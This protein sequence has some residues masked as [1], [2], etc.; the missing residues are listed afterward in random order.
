MNRILLLFAF[1][2]V[3]LGYSQLVPLTLELP[4]ADAQTSSG[5][6]GSNYGTDGT[7]Q[8][9]KTASSVFRS[10]LK[11]N[12]SSIPADAVITS[13][14]L[15]LTPSGVEGIPTT[16]ATELYLDVCNS[17]WTE[18][19]I[20]HSSNISN[21]TL[22]PTVTVSNL[23]SG[24]REFE[25]KNFV[26]A[27]AD[28]R[29]PNEGWR[30]RRKDETTNATTAYYTKEVKTSSYHPKLVIQYYLRSSVSAATIVH[31]STLTSNDGSISPT[32]L[33]GSS[34]TMT[35]RWF[36]SSG[37]QI[38]TSQNLTGVGKGWYGL[39][40][41][42]SVAGDTTYMAFIVGTECEDVSITFDPGP[43]YID[44][45]RFTDFVSGS[46]TSAINYPQANNGSNILMM[47]ERWTNGGVWYNARDVIKFRLWVD[48]GCQVNSAVMTLVGNAH[49]ALGTPNT[50]ELCR[51]TANW[52]EFGVAHTNMP[53]STATGKIAVP[54][55]ATGNGNATP[56]IASFFN[57]WKNN[58]VQNY[59]MLFQLQSYASN[60]YTR[61][62]FHSSDATVAS[63]RPKINFSI[64]TETCNL[65]RKGVT[66]V[67]YP[68][69]TDYADLN[70]TVYPPTWAVPPY[71][72]MISEQPVPDFSAIYRSAQVG[73]P[74]SPFKDT[75]YIDSTIFYN[76]GISATSKS[77]TDV[78]PG[79]YFVS[80][81]DKLGKR[82][83]NRQVSVN[84]A[85]NAANFEVNSGMS[86]SSLTDEF[87]T[88]AVVG[89]ALMY[90]FI[91]EKSQGASISYKVSNNS[92][93]VLIGLLNLSSNLS[94]KTDLVHGFIV[95]GT[96]ASIVSSGYINPS[97]AISPTDEFV[98]TKEGS[99][100]KFYVNGVFKLS[101]A[102]PS[103]F[104]YKTGVLGNGST[105]GAAGIRISFKP[106]NIFSFKKAW[107]NVTRVDPGSCMGSFGKITGTLNVF[108]F[109]SASVINPSMVLTNTST[110][111][112]QP[113]DV[114]V[115]GLDFS[116][117]NLLPGTYTLTIT[118]NW[119]TSPS[120]PVV[121]TMNI[122]VPT[123]IAWQNL[124]NATD[125]PSGSGSLLSTS[126]L[127]GS[128]V[129]VNELLPAIPGNSTIIDFEL[130]LAGYFY[131]V[132]F[133]GFSML[134]PVGNGVA[135]LGLTEG[136][137]S[138]GT[139]YFTGWKFYKTAFSPYYAI[140]YQG[141][142][143]LS[144][145][146]SFLGTDRLRFIY[147]PVS[148]IAKLH[149]LTATGIMGV[150]M[151]QIVNYGLNP[152]VNVKRLH[153]YLATNIANRG[154]VRFST[155]ML[156]LKDIIYAKLERKLLGVK[157]KVTLNKF[158]FFY[159]EE[160]ASTSNLTYNVYDKNNVVV[161]STTTPYL[162]NT[163]PSTDP[164]TGNIIT[165]EYG[166]NRYSLDVTSIS[167]GS[168][169][170]EVINEKNEKLYLRFIK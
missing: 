144:S 134:I 77:F 39:K 99:T 111:A 123:Q 101:T 11:F 81:F 9:S 21:N 93:E 3:F 44:D 135:Y 100:M 25:I 137:Q 108:T 56:D 88:T 31:T 124:M 152:G 79:Q 50:S 32:I 12:L 20:T 87:V 74:G 157:Y 64:K 53:A 89:K 82:I 162:V 117:S 5:S 18:G 140:P 28:G 51:I 106:I 1:F 94:T 7:M 148:K 153:G 57:I 30:I 70:T 159:D 4:S 37:T 115:T 83:Y 168:Y 97:F 40:Y 13:A 169:V 165:R 78:G 104:T 156:C 52:S 131:T 110:A 92:G 61:M 73:D 119:S 166:D 95:N 116:Y 160:Y 130:N 71:H 125:L 35:Y 26:Q 133:G 129:S 96:T 147:D 114:G 139:S 112:V 103:T 72:Y 167:A 68:S 6:P 66:T 59:G 58:N 170:L 90:S 146:I 128:A 76:N 19:G 8:V 136:V 98:L 86:F 65:D 38:G 158:Y 142:D 132:S 24:K 149:K 80:V 118:Y 10:F 150:Q 85:A 91:N 120:V 164:V 122:V 14:I 161:L 107:I 34:T 84:P 54:A 145:P 143:P 113:M 33:N 105:G 2:C 16:N 141:G 29:L 43:N 15:Q 127:N 48:P 55:I 23:V 47:H 138:P 109:F 155:N 102:L 75:V 45:A 17:S 36:N 49:N 151:G 126:N 41:Y 67:T 63:N 69:S 27:I 121:A 62:Q 42:G 163:S 154:F 22:F 60:L 46:G